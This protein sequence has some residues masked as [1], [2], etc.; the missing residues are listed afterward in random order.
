MRRR[1]AQSPTST[2]VPEGPL[3]Q[4]LIGDVS[5]HPANKRFR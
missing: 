3:Y 2:H 4:L 5:D 1:P